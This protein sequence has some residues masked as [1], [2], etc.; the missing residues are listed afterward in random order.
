MTMTVT[1]PTGSEFAFVIVKCDIFHIHTC[2]T[3]KTQ[4]EKIFRCLGK[5]GLQKILELS[6][7]RDPKKFLELSGMPVPVPVCGVD[8]VNNYGAHCCTLITC[9][10]T[11]LI[12][13]NDRYVYIG[14][15]RVILWVKKV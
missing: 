14:A 10:L 7:K 8:Q 11:E 4:H 3:L 6:R 1:T 15:F 12:V 9:K 13:L 2:G 5:M